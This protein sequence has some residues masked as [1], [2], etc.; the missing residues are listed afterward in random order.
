MT[1]DQKS[2][3]V[4]VHY[5]EYRYVPKYVRM[6]LG[7]LSNHFDEVILVTNKRPIKTEGIIFDQNISILL[8][9]NEGYDLGMFYKAFKTINPANYHQIACI[10]DSNILFNQLN[11]VF[12]WS[13]LNKFD[14]WGLIDS[15]EKPWFSK[16]SNNY[17][18][19]SHF[20]VFNRKAISRL[21]EFFDSI[22]VENIFA[23]TDPVKLRHLVINSWEIGLTQYL[24]GKGLS[25][26]SFVD[27]LP[28]ANLYFTGKTTNI[29]HKLYPEL[30]QSGYP[31]IKKKII[32]KTNWKH[33]LQPDR[34]WEKMIRQYGNR[35]WEIDGLIEELI[36]IK[37]DSGNQSFLKIKRKLLDAYNF[38]VNR[39][40]A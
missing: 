33:A 12:N 28:F 3:C 30:I 1:V 16:H 35:H 24:I 6:Y 14:F 8:V 36:Q 25:Y 21:P 40:V 13:K 31:L 19:Q 15:H 29:G 10:N 38:I 39:D 20:I 5:S 34:N 18:I 32:T 22:E 17:H 26:G 4:F 11:P 9:K 23:E 27:S 2:L 37:S 7:E